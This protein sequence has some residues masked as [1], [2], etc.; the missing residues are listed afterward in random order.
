VQGHENSLSLVL[1]SRDSRLRL[2]LRSRTRSTICLI[3]LVCLEEVVPI[4]LSRRSISCQNRPFSALTCPSSHVEDPQRSKQTDLTSL[5]SILSARLAFCEII[6]TFTNS[7]LGMIIA[8]HLLRFPLYRFLPSW[9]RILNQTA[10]FAPFPNMKVKSQAVGYSRTMPG[11]T[12]L[13]ETTITLNTFP[14]RMGRAACHQTHVFNFARPESRPSATKMIFY[15][16]FHTSFP[17]L[18]HVLSLSLSF[19]LSLSH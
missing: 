14:T 3:C 15:R 9:D 13:P 17:L 11:Y 1:S 19:S 10:P 2:Y 4:P 7:S 16:P 6:D 12:R 5:Q 8:C 18:I